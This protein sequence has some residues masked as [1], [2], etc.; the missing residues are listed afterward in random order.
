MSIGWQVAVL[1]GA[2]T[3]GGLI[4]AARGLW[5]S[6]RPDPVA[7]LDRLDPAKRVVA[8]TRTADSARAGHPLQRLFGQKF[9]DAAASST[10]VRPP[11]ADLALLG[12]SVEGY[13]AMRLASGM[14]GLLIPPLLTGLAITLGV[15]IPFEV[16]LAASLAVG[17][18]LFV[19]A[20]QDVRRKA[21]TA[22]TEFRTILQRYMELIALERAANVGAVQALEEAGAASTSWVLLRINRTLLEASYASQPPWDYLRALAEQIDVPALRDLADTMKASGQ[23]GAAIY[24]RLL[25]RSKSLSTELQ[26]DDRAAAEE[27]SERMIVPMSLLAVCFI[28]AILYPMAT[29]IH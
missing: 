4:I 20:D 24:T 15:T 1:G 17:I 21:A 5:P 26:T 2:S 9:L 22:R 11:H 23:D 27:S 19:S 16:P 14:L 10:L 28:A 7:V 8:P 12:I 3:G 29:R 13:V 25:S 6:R 18:L